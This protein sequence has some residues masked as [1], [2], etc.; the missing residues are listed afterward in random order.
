MKNFYVL[1]IIHM[2]KKLRLLNL[3]GVLVVGFVA[4]PT[5]AKNLLISDLFDNWVPKVADA[6]EQLLNIDSTR[7]YGGNTS[8]IWCMAGNNIEI[9]TDIVYDEYFDDATMYL[10]FFSPYRINDIKN[11]NVSIDKSK[12]IMKKFLIQDD[13]TRVSFTV[14]SEEIEANQ[15]YYAFVVPVDMYDTIWA[16]TGEM[17]FNL[18]KHICDYTYVEDIVLNP[19][20]N[21]F[22][23]PAILKSISFSNLWKDIW[24]ARMENWVWTWLEI[25]TKAFVELVHPLEWYLIKNNGKED[26]VMTI[27]Y[28]TD[29]SNSLLLSKDLDAGWN[30]LW[31]TTTDNPFKN[32]AKA[33]ATMVLDLTNWQ[34]TN[35]IQ[36]WKTFIN[37]TKFVL[38]KAY[39]VFVT[40]AWTY[41]WIN[42][43]WTVD[44]DNTWDT[45]ADNSCKWMD[46]ANIQHIF[47]DWV[48][49]FNWDVVDGDVVQVAIFEPEDG[50]WRS[51]WAVNMSDGTFSYT[52]KREWEHNFVFT[53]WCKEI[54][55]KV[56]TSSSHSYSQE[57]VD[58]YNWAYQNWIIS[59]STID[60]SGVYNRLPNPSMKAVLLN[61]A[62]YLWLNVD[63]V[64]LSFGDLFVD[65]GSYANRAQFATAL[66]RVLWWKQYDGGDPYYKNH[67]RALNEAG[68]MT[69]SNIASDAMTDEIKWYVVMTLKKAADYYSFEN[70]EDPMAVIACA[71]NI[72]ACPV[73]CRPRASLTNN[74]T[75]TV[76]FPNGEVTSR[77][78]FDGTYTA[79]KNHNIHWVSIAY[80]GGDD[81]ECYN[82][83]LHHLYINWTEID[84]DN[85]YLSSNSCWGIHYMWFSDDFNVEQWWVLQIKIEW[86]LD[87]ALFS[88]DDKE[89]DY[90][91]KLSFYG[92]NWK[93]DVLAE[94]NLAPIR[95]VKKGSLT[96]NEDVLVYLESQSD[97]GDVTE[98]VLWI[99][100][101]DPSYDVYNV[102]L[103]TSLDCSGQTLNSD[104]Q[105][106]IEDGWTLYDW[107][108]TITVVNGNVVQYINS[109]DYV[110]YDWSN[111]RNVCISKDEYPDYFKISGEYRRVFANKN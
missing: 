49:K 20:L 18:S 76:E 63:S 36:I 51:L 30:F 43:Y 102:W 35:L 28:D 81:Y 44:N 1:T 99:D 60:D 80:D 62:N 75:K 56:D 89:G 105:Q 31:I 69:V 48:I 82:N 104:N 110:V 2:I 64:E 39:A 58:A 71:T 54:Y 73:A 40:D 57:L 85:W 37:A 95:I 19:G 34:T 84:S 13:D 26:V 23:T 11:W 32:I 45:E 29:N 46:E 98:Y 94:T 8:E 107:W 33:A 67:F 25:W 90:V 4:M 38:W 10:L 5:Y 65:E 74:L 106:S 50:Y 83:M 15:D 92:E 79:Y 59:E 7:W 14:S 72:V 101:E 61:F 24:F 109:I 6:Y 93:D 87:G 77:V 12:I 66:S 16:P 42:N 111:Y 91:M 78:I 103:F 108:D 9:T 53:N 41:G 68:I 3:L 97:G 21:S 22:S 96:P 27:E 88:G 86:E 17:H 100:K 47:E 52:T 70:C 55:Y